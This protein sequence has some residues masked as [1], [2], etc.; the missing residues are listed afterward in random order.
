MLLQSYY[1]QQLAW[2]GP[3]RVQMMCMD[4][5]RARVVS[6]LHGFAMDAVSN[7]ESASKPRRYTKSICCDHEQGT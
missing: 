6:T 2:N 7:I 4:G 5:N 1:R 3:S